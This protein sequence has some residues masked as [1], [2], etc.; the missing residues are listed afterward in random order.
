MLISIPLQKN[1][2]IDFLSRAHTNLLKGFAILTVLWGHIGSSY[3][4]VGI[5]WIAGIGVSLFL[6]C[7]GYGLEASFNKNGLKH[8]WK[9]RFW[10]VVIPYWVIYLIAAALTSK[11][12]DLHMVKRILLFMQANWY[13][14]FILIVYI[15]YWVLKM[16]QIHYELERKAFYILLFSSFVAWFVVESIFFAK[17]MAPSLLARQMF[18]FPIG[19][20]FYDYY[21]KVKIFFESSSSKNIVGMLIVSLISVLALFISQKEIVLALPYLLSNIISLLTVMPLSVSLIKLSC[22]MSRIFN[23]Y[24]FYFLGTVS[25]EI[26]LIQYFSRNIVNSSPYSLYFCFLITI[27]LGWIFQIGYSKFT[28]WRKNNRL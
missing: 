6:I 7:S 14:R 24:L 13:V 2:K 3:N 12:F 10:A 17:D 27:I 9:K 19:I 23:N 21:N 15:I 18:S 20:I 11:E 5:Q 25:Y 22:L 1:E 16:F 28:S 8:F 26:Y 4:V